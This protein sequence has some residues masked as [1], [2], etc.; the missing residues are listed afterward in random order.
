MQAPD[1]VR[2][3]RGTAEGVL[4]TKIGTIDLPKGDGVISLT[5]PEISGSQALQFR[6]LTLRPVDS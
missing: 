4:Q 2:M 3:L 6:L 5:A 1:V